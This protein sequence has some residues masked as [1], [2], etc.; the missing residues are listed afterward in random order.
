MI[1]RLFAALLLS[2]MLAACIDL[3]ADSG[4]PILKAPGLL[5]GQYAYHSGDMFAK[6]PHDLD[7]LVIRPNGHYIIMPNGSK[8]KKLWITGVWK[9]YD[10]GEGSPHLV[11][12]SRGYPIEIHGSELRLII[13][14][15]MGQ[16]WVTTL[17]QF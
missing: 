6:D 2:T 17:R 15:D 11:L 12:D 16:Y 9:I 3:D 4:R 13:D 7:Q 10:P 14:G 8:E 1:T 5:V